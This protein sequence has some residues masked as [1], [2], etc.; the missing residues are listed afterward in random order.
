MFVTF[1]YIVLVTSS[2][3]GGG[4]YIWVVVSTI[5]YDVSI[6]VVPAY[7]FVVLTIK[8]IDATFL[9]FTGYGLGWKVY[10]V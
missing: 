3:G 6:W 7:D 4:V 8:T 5:Q 1:L 10:V 9:Y 2:P